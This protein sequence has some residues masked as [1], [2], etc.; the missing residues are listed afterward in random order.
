LAEGWVEQEGTQ[1][2][3]LALEPLAGGESISKSF[4]VTLLENSG[5]VTIL[6]PRILLQSDASG[7]SINLSTGLGNNIEV[8]RVWSV[9]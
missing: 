2:Y 9:G 7:N 5:L 3:Q 6:E 1:R 4:A 8:D